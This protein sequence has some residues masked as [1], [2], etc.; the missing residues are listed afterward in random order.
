[1]E[2]AERKLELQQL[3]KAREEHLRAEVSDRRV[4]SGAVQG[5][6]AQASPQVFPVSSGA[7]ASHSVD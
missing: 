5:L 2:S 4:K 1:V 7:L 3:P 6:L